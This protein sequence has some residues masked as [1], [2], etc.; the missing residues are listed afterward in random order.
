MPRY[1]LMRCAEARVVDRAHTTRL[2]PVAAGLV[3]RLNDAFA[4]GEGVVLIFTVSLSGSYQGA[5]RMVSTAGQAANTGWAACRLEW[6]KRADVPYS[7]AEHLINPLSDPPQPVRAGKNGTEIAPGVAE[8]LLGMLQKAASISPTPLSSVGPSTG[9]QKGAP[10]V[11]SSGG[12]GGG[13][14][15]MGG[16]SA[17]VAIGMGGGGMGGMVGAGMMGMPDPY[18]M[19]MQGMQGM[20][21]MHAM[22]A[23]N[24]MLAMQMMNPAMM[25]QA[26]AAGMM[27]P[28]AAAMMMGGMPGGWWA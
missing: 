14:G 18:L 12:G 24:P 15:G 16:G 3:D 6:I 27:N 17:G 26:A 1:F 19:G 4:S 2:W 9:E 11:G 21:G 5:A 22:H 25:M 28:M 23:M 10:L 8:E 7:E 20:Q 13:G